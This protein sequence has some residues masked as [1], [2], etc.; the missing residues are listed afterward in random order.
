MSDD[1][2]PHPR[3]TTALFGHAD[4]EQT[5]LAAYRS[6]RIPHAWLI[7]GPAGVGKA[8]LAYRLARFMLA[9]P[10][11]GAAEVQE[12]STLAVLPDDPTARRIA[13]DA[14]SDLLGL[15]RVL[16]ETS[17][18]KT[19][20]NTTIRIDQVRRTVSFFGSTAGEG[21]WRVAIVDSVDELEKEGENA[22][23]KILE[24]PPRRSL[25]LLVSHTP[26]RVLP[27]IRSRT[28]HLLLRPLA[29]EDVARAAA[30][31]SGRD[32]ADAELRE[33]A[34]A[35]DGSVARAL[36]LLDGPTLA[37]RRQV[38]QLLAGLPEIDPRG[39]HALS[40]A[41]GGTEPKTLAVFVDLVNRWLSERLARDASSAAKAARTAHAYE[42]VN[43][44][45]R[46]ADAYNLD[47]KP[48]VFSVFGLL[49][50][51]ARG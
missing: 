8:T 15:E 22:L 2:F 23:L 33:A 37:L 38:L 46:D 6:G 28:R 21:G 13:G 40:D 9:H 48:L 24:E 51:M 17:K 4:A 20:L 36:D 5:L 49:A 1:E 39:L 44:A 35:A 47:R 19:R 11:P 26:G 16:S 42:A 30:L 34:A 41:I 29:P 10:D 43:R 18:D 14:H 32:G 31:A 50:E 12:A 3:A 7:G 25:L 45:A 27:T